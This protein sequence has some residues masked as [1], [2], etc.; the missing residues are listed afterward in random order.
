MAKKNILFNSFFWKA[1]SLWNALP[2]VVKSSANFSSFKLRLETFYSGSKR[3]YGH[4]H[5]SNLRNTLLR[6]RLRLC[7]SSPV[8]TGGL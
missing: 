3:N 2:I 4:L 5:G 8:A 7:H 1:A 6:C